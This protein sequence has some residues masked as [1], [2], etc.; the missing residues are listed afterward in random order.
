MHIIWA[1][2]EA[3]PYAKTGGLADVS[4]ALP[5]ALSKRGHTVSVFMPFYPQV[6]AKLKLQLPVRYQM[7]PVPMGWGT[8]WAQLL[9]HRVS[10]RL[11]FYFV[12]YNRFF[13]RPTLY[14]WH[15]T[16]FS[17]NAERYIFLSRAIMQAIVTLGMRPDIIH[18]N[19]WHTALCDVYLKSHIYRQYDNF[20]SCRSVHTLHN[21]GYQGV[22]DKSNI[23]WTGLGWN[24]FNPTCLE[25]YDRLGL[26]K[27]GLM[28]ADMV[29]TVSPTY[30]QEILTPGFAFS[31]EGPLR[32][33]HASGRLRGILNGIDVN[34]WN[35]EADHYLP[36]RFSV[37]DLRGKKACKRILQEEFR[38]PL[39]P[40][41][42]LFG[43]ISRLAYQKGI[44]IF[45]N[46]IWDILHDDDVQFV[47]LGTGEGWLHNRLS[48]L[49]GRFPE[50]FAVYLGYSDRLSHLIEAGSDFFVMPSRYE[51]CGLNQMYSMRYGTAPIV[52]STGGLADTVINFAPDKLDECTGFKFNDLTPVALRDTLRWATSIYN[53]NPK[54]FKQVVVNGMSRDF[55]WNHT[56]VE[57]ER[58]YNDAKS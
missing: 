58:L 50:K 56:A 41:V 40:D 49:A 54:A 31:L 28:T 51:P 52:R 14:D 44:D 27:G 21:I 29:S 37:G 46:A 53:T 47:V 45:A 15:G 57:Y 48:E 1:T 32:H 24:Y 5:L 35:P 23:F 11:S 13:D 36:R 25:Y 30:A 16:E 34:E 39:L 2:S 12:E 18:T 26:L 17:D 4:A 3:Q 10:D 20:S 38:L 6:M 43:I 42:P 22:F 19:D 55:S 33:V 7:L 8:E 9:E